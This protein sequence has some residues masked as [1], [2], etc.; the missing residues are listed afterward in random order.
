MEGSKAECN[1]DAIFSSRTPLQPML[2]RKKTPS[3]LRRDQKRKAEFLSM[4]D[5]LAA[6][7]VK[8]DSKSYSDTSDQKKIFWN[9]WI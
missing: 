3:M 8:E 2:R 1:L 5:A 4:K 6:V 7:E 9:L